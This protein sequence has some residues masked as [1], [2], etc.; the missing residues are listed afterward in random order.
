MSAGS[1][2][3]KVVK[4]KFVVPD[5]P[6]GE[7]QTSFEKH[8]KVIRAE[9]KKTKG[10]NATVLKELVQLTYAMR[11]KDISTNPCDIS[12]LFEKYQDIQLC[13]LSTCTWICMYI[14]T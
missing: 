10:G 6:I 1:P 13:K 5:I 9:M 12:H 7:D 14:C 4:R 2:F 11:R 8:N 3:T